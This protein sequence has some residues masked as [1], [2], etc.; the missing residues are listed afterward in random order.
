MK[1]IRCMP[2]NS[3][4]KDPSSASPS[5]R[6]SLE[7]RRM[8]IDG[9]AIYE[10]GVLKPKSP[11]EAEVHVTIETAQGA[12]QQ[13][14]PRSREIAW[15]RAHEQELR[16][17]AGQWVILE[18]EELIANGPDPR[19]LVVAA[20]AKGVHVPYL[21]LVEDAGDNAVKFGL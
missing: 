7:V 11:L 1:S 13:P 5:G 12:A 21:F 8:P 19:A 15:R 10:D 6:M 4:S 14:H 18:G 3:A 20:R 9:D 17:L 2:S 16:A